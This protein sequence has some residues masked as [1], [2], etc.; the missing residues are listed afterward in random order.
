MTLFTPKKS[1][2]NRV[3]NGVRF[4]IVIVKE[5]FGVGFQFLK[6]KLKTHIRGVFGVGNNVVKTIWQNN[7]F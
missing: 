6:N 2:K 4:Q 3:P 7:N 1:V 5:S